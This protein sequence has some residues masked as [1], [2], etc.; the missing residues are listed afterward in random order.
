MQDRGSR[1]TP[2]PATNT[3][4][5]IDD[6]IASAAAV[7]EDALDADGVPPRRVTAKDVPRPVHRC[8]PAR[9]PSPTVPEE[10]T[11]RVPVV[12]L[13][14]LA[15]RSAQLDLQT[16]SLSPFEVPGRHVIPRSAVHDAP[17]RRAPDP[18]RDPYPRWILGAM[19]LVASVAAG[20]AVAMRLQQ[21]DAAPPLPA[22]AAAT[23][24]PEAALPLPT[25]RPD[26]GAVAPARPRKR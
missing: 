2:R 15:R 17:T 3:E 11:E 5:A 12:S 23:E 9:P 7:V 24:L 13:Q 20:A 4:A 26:A 1:A 19:A 10:P 18:A 21:D 14:T 22:A 6:V 25:P 16:P 8:P